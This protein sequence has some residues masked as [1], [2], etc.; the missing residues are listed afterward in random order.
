MTVPVDEA[1]DADE[2]SSSACSG[3][4]ATWSSSSR[5]S[6]LIAGNV[7]SRFLAQAFWRSLMVGGVR[8]NEVN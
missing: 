5:S 8:A 6:K 7:L 2:E 1:E 3:S 4:S